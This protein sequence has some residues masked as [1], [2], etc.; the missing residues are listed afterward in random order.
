M[1]YPELDHWQKILHSC[2]R[3]GYLMELHPVDSAVKV[4]TRSGCD[5]RFFFHPR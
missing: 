5:R 3:C 4:C 2:L 1:T